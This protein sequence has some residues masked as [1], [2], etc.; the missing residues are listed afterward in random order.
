MCLLQQLPHCLVCVCC[1]GRG[2]ATVSVS[3]AP[4][5]S[6]TRSIHSWQLQHI[7]PVFRSHLSKYLQRVQIRST[8]ACLRLTQQVRTIF[9]IPL[10]A[11]GGSTCSAAAKASS[12]EPSTL[13]LSTLLPVPVHS[14]CWDSF[15]CLF[16]Q[17]GSMSR[18]D[19]GCLPCIKTAKT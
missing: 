7:A 14:Y 11:A 19:D 1:H 5:L 10:F 18:D 4:S 6:S 16:L 13:V 12:P 8:I 3:V 2:G 17:A 15:E 9:L